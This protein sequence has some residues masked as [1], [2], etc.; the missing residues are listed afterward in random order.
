MINT[1]YF[2]TSDY[3]NVVILAILVMFALSSA[4]KCLRRSQAMNDALE[5]QFPILNV[6]T[7]A[8]FLV[9][10]NCVTEREIEC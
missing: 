2:C 8:T 1:V 3:N 5:M 6:K 10:R 7:L 4:R 9:G